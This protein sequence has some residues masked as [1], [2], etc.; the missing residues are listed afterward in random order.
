MINRVA[1][2]HEIHWKAEIK[3]RQNGQTA[4]RSFLSL[5]SFNGET[6]RQREKEER[7]R[8]ERYVGEGE[9]GEGKRRENLGGGLNEGVG[10]QYNICVIYI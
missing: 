8:M 4:N 5:L 3:N 2:A 7:P 6:E 1:L 9:G 10:L